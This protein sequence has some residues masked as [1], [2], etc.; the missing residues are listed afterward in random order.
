[1]SIISSYNFETMKKPSTVGFMRKHARHSLPS[2]KA[3]M[4]VRGITKLYTDFDLLVRR[5]RRGHGD[6]VAIKRLMLLPD[7]SNRRKA[8][9]MRQA[10][11]KALDDLEAAGATLLELETNRSTA[12]AREREMAI[13]DAVDDLAR[14]RKGT[15]P[16]G[17]PQLEWTE[18]QQIIMKR[19]WFNHRDYQSNPAAVR[20]I[21]AAGVKA[22]MCQLRKMCG[23]SGRVMG[24]YRGPRRATG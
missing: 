11:Y 10:L 3:L 13:R 23:P 24:G 21:N 14:T 9:G 22:S 2:Q 5:R 4:D 18:D 17:R 8:G 20:A 1:M 12:N 6:V 7:P 19:H 16:P 15:R